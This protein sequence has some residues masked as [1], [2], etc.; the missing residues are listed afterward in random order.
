MLSIETHGTFGALH[1]QSIEQR[2][3]SQVKKFKISML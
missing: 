1:Q 3:K 2:G